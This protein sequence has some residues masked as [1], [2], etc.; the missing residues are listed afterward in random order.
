MVREREEERKR[1][2]EERL[3]LLEEEEDEEEDLQPQRTPSPPP[4]PYTQVLTECSGTLLDCLR[5]D[6][7][8]LSQLEQAEVLSEDMILDIKCR[9]NRHDKVNRLIELLLRLGPKSLR[10]F[11]EALKQNEDHYFL[12]KVLS[13]RTFT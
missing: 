6:K 10:N 1:Q 11:I 7:N 8:L 5:L 2:A 13:F 3:L 12:A 9:P 4:I